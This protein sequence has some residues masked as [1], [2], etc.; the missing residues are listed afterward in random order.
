MV[1]YRF[2]SSCSPLE[3]VRFVSINSPDGSLTRCPEYIEDA[4][5]DIVADPASRY[6]VMQGRWTSYLYDNVINR[7]A[8]TYLIESNADPLDRATSA[9]V[10]KRGLERAVRRLT[11]AGKIV[12]LIEPTPEYSDNAAKCYVRSRRLGRDGEACAEK[13]IEMEALTDR[14]E[15]ILAEVARGNPSVR[16][17]QIDGL[18]CGGSRCKPWDSEG[19]LYY[20]SN[21][22]TQY[23]AMKLEPGLR[24]ALRR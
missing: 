24:Q 10:L 20:D 23:G 4:L 11:D 5:A 19:L 15:K 21:H 17:V 12:I 18:L 9:R 1:R 2:V 6:V 13:A 8:Q 3:G 14:A 16:L 22:L 7:A